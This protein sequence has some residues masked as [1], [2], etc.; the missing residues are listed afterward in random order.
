MKLI[1][2]GEAVADLLKFLVLKV[3]AG[4][5]KGG[6]KESLTGNDRE[7]KGVLELKRSLLFLFYYF[8]FY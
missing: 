6:F 7:S 4:V 5:E 2:E 8:F 1:A 3:G